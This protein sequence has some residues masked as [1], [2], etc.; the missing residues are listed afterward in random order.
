M[1]EIITILLFWFGFSVLAKPIDLIDENAWLWGKLGFF[2]KYFFVLVST[3]FVFLTLHFDPNFTPHFLSLFLFWVL[4]GKFEYPSHVLFGFIPA[5]YIGQYINFEYTM[6]AIVWLIVYGI[7]EFLVKKYQHPIIQTGLYKS[8]ARFL[9]VP[10]GL[11]V[12]F[13]DYNI[14]LFVIPWL[15]SMQIVR[16][17]IKKDVI[18]IHRGKGT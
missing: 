15:L 18:K 1:N 5:I 10:F 2:L 6:L 14:I 16:Y 11:S 13:S 17:L 9:I 3:Y 7:L 12:Y 8:L 4:N